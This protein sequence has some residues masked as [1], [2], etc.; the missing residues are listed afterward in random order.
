MI[1]GEK[2]NL[3][4]R[5]LAQ[6]EKFSGETELHLEAY[7]NGREQGFSVANFNTDKVKRV[8]FS[9][10][11]NTDQIVVYWGVY[12]DFSNA[13]NCPNA[14]IYKNANFFGD[15][16]IVGAARFIAEYLEA[17]PIGA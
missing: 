4:K 10:Y 16:D 5:I 2:M 12:S 11:R 1:T 13:G 17:L 8:A 6:V 15:N 7:A 3:A 9:E 14:E